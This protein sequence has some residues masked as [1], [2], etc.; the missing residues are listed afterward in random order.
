MDDDRGDSRL[1]GL[2]EAVVAVNADMGLNVVLDKIVSTA[3]DLVGARYGALGVVAPGTQRLSEFVTFGI[4]DDERE[5][6]GPNPTGHGVLG[7]LIKHPQPLRLDDVSKHPQS[8]G[9]PAAHPPMKT[10]LGVP[11]RVED[12]VFG[13]LYLT[14]KKGGLP[15]TLGDEEVLVAL[16]AA[17]GIAIRKAELYHLS[18]K[19]TQWLG[20][21]AEMTNALLS[22]TPRHEA[23]T[24]LCTRAREVADVEVASILLG[25]RDGLIVEVAEGASR[26]LAEGNEIAADGPIATAFEKKR[27]L[28]IEGGEWCS[29]FGLEQVIVAPMQSAGAVLGVLI[30]G[31]ESSPEHL[32]IEQDVTMAA[33]FAEQAA[34]AIQ[35]AGAQSDRVRLGI[36]EERDRIARDLH[37][38]V[39]QRL[40]AVGLSLRQVSEQELPAADQERRLEQAIDDMDDTVR[41]LRRSIFR[42]HSRPGEGDLRSDLEGI[43]LEAHATLGFPPTLVIEGDVL[44]LTDNLAQ[45]L[46]AVLRESLSNV[47]RHADASRVTISV[48]ADDDRV[49]LAVTDNGRGLS[50]GNH[51]GGLA[52]MRSRAQ[53]HGGHCEFHTLAEGGTQIV[54]HA[55]SAYE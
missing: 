23:L 25:P 33:G 10:F 54:W 41:E 38:L 39:V 17:A 40:F 13:N 26:V 46:V 35:L 24:L 36:Y 45:D 44:S 30:L 27:A 12:K 53:G 52:N 15:F 18:R 50:P 19:R 1:R 51:E 20:A 3:C 42:L 16:A 2:L 9:F 32:T 7:A 21:A 14:E 28:M 49:E 47:A 6:I 31:R 37:D 29:D 11:V 22:Q 34:L 55:P 48:T 43:V 8:V 4:P 5:V